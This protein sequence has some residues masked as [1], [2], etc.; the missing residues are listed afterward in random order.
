MLEM[1]HQCHRTMFYEIDG[2]WFEQCAAYGKVETKE[3]AA[4]G[5]SFIASFFFFFCFLLEPH[6]HTMIIFRLFQT[7]DWK[8]IFKKWM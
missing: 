8:L 5:I 6:F 3:T 7:A 4:D 2:D 1:G